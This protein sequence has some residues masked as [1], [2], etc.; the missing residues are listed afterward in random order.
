[1]IF[2]ILYLITQQT[3]G[4]YSNVVISI[5]TYCRVFF[6]IKKYILDM[7]AWLHSEIRSI[8][9]INIVPVFYTLYSVFSVY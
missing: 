6:M 3:N 8:Y 1:M 4:F 7:N 9:N 5:I 2:T